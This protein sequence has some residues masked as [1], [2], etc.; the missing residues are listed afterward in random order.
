M[1]WR[2][3]KFD[4]AARSR[5]EVLGQLKELFHDLLLQAGGDAEVALEWMREIDRRYGIY[6]RGVS[7]EEFLEW[8]KE[9][10]SVQAGEGGLVMGARA[11]RELR[12]ESLDAIFG[13]LSRDATGDHRV[14]DAGDGRER[15]PETRP[16][17]FG[18][19]AELLDAAASVRNA[20]RRG[21]GDAGIELREEDLEVYETE[22]LSSCAT[23]LCL[24]LSHS[25]IL[26]GEDRITPA[27]RVALALTELVR[28]RYPKDY[29]AVVTF[30]DDAEEVPLDRLPYVSVGPYHTNTRGA[31]R[32]ARSLLARRKQKNRQILMVTDG[33]PSAL[34]ER[35]G[36]VYKN[37]FGLDRRVVSKTLEEADACRREG[38]PITTFMLTDDPTLV[39]FVERF[40]A[41]NRGRAYYSGL[42]KLGDFL[43]VDY[44]R[45]RRRTVR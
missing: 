19:P 1:H 17:R 45:N 2:Y 34:T 33:K 36:E 39:E 27:K 11:E 12:T 40:T 23:V 24:D 10:G 26:Y 8:L 15:L 44:L 3:E 31:L 4:L 38:I 16:W 18:D 35:D 37:P 13:S 41:T 29:L 7:E 21:V 5:D 28:T 20:L 43:L 6:S 22:H 32:L 14:A 42:G 9:G 30:G 25:M